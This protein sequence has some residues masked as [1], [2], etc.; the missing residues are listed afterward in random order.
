VND[1]L[2]LIIEDDFDASQ[3]FAKALEVQGLTTEIISE[4]DKAMERLRHV[5]PFIIVLDLH[6]P[7]VDGTEILAWVR[8]MPNL[9]ETLVLVVTADARMGEMLHDQADLVLLK[10]ATFTQIRDFTMRLIRRRQNAAAATTAEATPP[11]TAATPSAPAAPAPES[12]ATPAAAPI[13][14]AVA[15]EMPAPAPEVIPAPV[16]E[17]AAAA[18]AAAPISQSVPKE[19]SA[20]AAE[21]KPAPVTESASPT[22]DAPTAETADAA[23]DKLS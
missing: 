6:L 11:P 9:K 14:E 7:N 17:A 22:P 2:A 18:P 8:S 3:I 4:G 1:Q 5:A 23:A 20:P 16:A 19:T 10:P 12:A 13:P 21:S 15:K